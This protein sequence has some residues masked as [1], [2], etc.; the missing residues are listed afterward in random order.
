MSKMLSIAGISLALVGG[1][2]VGSATIASAQ[3]LDIQVGPHGIRPVIRDN[4]N[5][6]RDACSPG[7]AMAAARDEGYH[8][9]R[10]V[11]VSDRR[12]VVEGMTNDGLDRISFANR[13]GCPEI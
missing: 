4:D 1:L 6:G 12:V 3:N 9:P 7:E 2:F 10:I 11:R 8:H 13:P 5:G